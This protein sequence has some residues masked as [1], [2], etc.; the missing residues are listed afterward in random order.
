[1][2]EIK[3]PKMPTPKQLAMAADITTRFAEASVRGSDEEYAAL[4]LA[5]HT[6]GMAALAEQMRNG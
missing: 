6:M 3:R 5:A 1:M 2:T 4:R